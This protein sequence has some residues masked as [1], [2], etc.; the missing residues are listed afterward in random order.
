MPAWAACDRVASRHTSEG[1]EALTR[2]LYRKV[3]HREKKD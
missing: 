1:R 2:R 3:I